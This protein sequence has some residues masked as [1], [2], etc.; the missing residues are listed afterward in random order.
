MAMNMLSLTFLIILVL[1]SFAAAQ[2]RDPWLGKRVFTKDGAVAK[3]GNETIDI[4]MI[5]FPVTVGDVNGDW[6]WLGRAWVQKKDVM[7]TQQAIDYYTGKIRLNP[8]SPS[9][10]S[11]RAMVWYEKGEIE[12][13]IKDATE[14]IRLDPKVAITHN[15]RGMAF[16]QKGEIDAAIKDY[17]EAIRLDP[18]HATAYYN[19][20]NTHYNKSDLDAAIKDYTEA[21]RLDPKDAKAYAGRG[22]SLE[23]K[24][25]F[26]AAIK[27][28]TEAIRLDPKYA[29]SLHG[30]ARLYATC[31]DDKYRDGKRAVE[32]ATK[33]CELSAWKDWG[34]ID[35][36][37]AAYAESGNW[38][39]AIK[40]QEQA[41]ELATDEKDK[42]GGR[43]RLELY[44][45]KKP[46]REEV[47]KK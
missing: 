29:Y 5:P 42:A 41:I 37:A 1:P 19:R 47:K 30:L 22:N 25:D 46:Y 26:D 15:N 31:P 8:S 7:E 43:E 3:V 14:A 9:N 23:A 10:W 35:T 2:E 17:T 27:D 12:I 20:G 4:G 28:Y 16:A 11:N 39:N 38:D 44:K 21:I 40:Y 33:A 18:K 24:G 45:N 36:L 13:A 32:L 6:L 34:K